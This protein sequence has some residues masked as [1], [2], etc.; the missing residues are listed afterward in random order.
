MCPYCFWKYHA[1]SHWDL[2]CIHM[3]CEYAAEH[4]CVRVHVCLCVLTHACAECSCVPDL[5][6]HRKMKSVLSCL[7]EKQNK[8]S[9]G[10][11]TS[12][13]RSS[14][15]QTVIGGGSCQP[16]VSEVCSS[17]DCGPLGAQMPPEGVSE[18]L[19]EPGGQRAG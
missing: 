19:E 2:S 14:R 10:Q 9:T 12:P 17:G 8:N 18:L 3:L 16:S 13:L 1:S 11:I 15:W 4:V 6:F 7:R 5:I